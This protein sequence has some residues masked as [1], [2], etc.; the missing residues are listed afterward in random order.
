MELGRC[1]SME[2]EVVE[3]EENSL[4]FVL[5][6]EGHTFANLLR[7]TLKKNEHVVYAAYNVGHP[8]LDKER[9]VIFIKTDGKET[10]AEA[11]K[12]AVQSIKGQINE[13]GQQF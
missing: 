6:G 7:R 12:K 3:K 8:L 4:E 11:L 5:A 10:P 9:P 13:F 1:D 2:I